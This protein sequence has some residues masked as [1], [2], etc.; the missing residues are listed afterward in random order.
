M[1]REVSRGYLTKINNWQGLGLQTVD[2]WM[3]RWMDGW[4]GGGLK[5]MGYQRWIG[6]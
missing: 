1:H 2:G 6:D 5:G 3:V 4:M